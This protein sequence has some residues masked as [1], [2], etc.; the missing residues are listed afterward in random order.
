MTKNIAVI[1]AGAWG[2]ALAKVLAECGH[3]TTIWCHESH[4]ADEMNTHHTNKTYLAG[5]LLPETLKA[6]ADFEF[7]KSADV[8][9]AVTPVQVTAGVFKDMAAFVK[10]ATPIIL[11]SKGIDTTTSRLLKDILEDTIPHAVPAALGGPN[12][13]TDVAA[14][15]P[16]AA[17]IACGDMEIAKR[18]CQLFENSAFRPYASD[19]VIGVE[20]GGAVKN[21][22]A[23]ACGI[24]DAL[25]LGE[26]AKATLIAR[27]LAEMIRLGEAYGASKD[28]FVGLS[29][30]GDLLLTCNSQTSRNFSFGHAVGRGGNVQEVLESRPT[31]AEGYY[32]TKIIT[33]FAREKGVDMPIANSL[34]N[35]LYTHQPIDEA[36]KDLLMRPLTTE[37]I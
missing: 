2:T 28:T 6:T 25:E 5:H 30:V 7:L 13:A 32:T 16:C 22:I 36:L 12:F 26:N 33:G 29:G 1:G 31:V 20:L 4:T 34:Y 23:I 19:D 3:D 15:K 9:L 27:G 24:S 35:I 11:C 21:V 37:E 17:T 18:L 14:R 10:D 8:I